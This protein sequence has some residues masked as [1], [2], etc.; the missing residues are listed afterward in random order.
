MYQA[1]SDACPKGDDTYESHQGTQYKPLVTSYR[2]TLSR[3]LA[4][5]CS[6]SDGGPASTSGSSASSGRSRRQYMA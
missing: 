2:S 5:P 1:S 3:H 4:T 6:S